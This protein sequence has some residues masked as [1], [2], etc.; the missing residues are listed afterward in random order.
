MLGVGGGGGLHHYSPLLCNTS[1]EEL[2]Q[3]RCLSGL[4]IVFFFESVYRTEKSSTAIL[5]QSSRPPFE[6]SKSNSKR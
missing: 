4:V 3:I 6:K 2:F 5:H 1:L